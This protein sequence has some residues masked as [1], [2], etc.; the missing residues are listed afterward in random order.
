MIAVKYKKI[1]NIKYCLYNILIIYIY[2]SIRLVLAYKYFLC[3]ENFL[4]ID[5][6][7]GNHVVLEHKHI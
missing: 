4:V 7:I 2:Y 1:S 5:R 6:M 3:I